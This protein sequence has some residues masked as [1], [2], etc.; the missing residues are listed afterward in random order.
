MFWLY[1]FACEKGISLGDISLFKF[2]LEGAMSI[3][4][5]STYDEEIISRR[6]L[7]S[8]G[9]ISEAKTWSK[10][11]FP[12]FIMELPPSVSALYWIPHCVSIGVR[13]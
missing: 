3:L 5:T 8:S 13:E 10:S 7:V 1:V 12:A 6:E 2:P 4:G 11:G 9:I